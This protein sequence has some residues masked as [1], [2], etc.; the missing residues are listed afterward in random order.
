MPLPVFLAPVV[1]FLLRE[2]IIKF[3]VM[4]VLFVVIAELM[5]LVV[6][7]LV[8]FVNPGGLTS[9]FSAIPSG[10]WFFWDA[11]RLDVGIPLYISAHVARFSIRR[12]P[13]VG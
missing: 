11:F 9:I 2:V 4:A 13:V 5:P 8:G 12:V 7:Y 1:T 3:F 10:V 6:N